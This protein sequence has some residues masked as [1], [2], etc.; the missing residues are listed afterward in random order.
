MDFYRR[1]SAEMQPKIELALKNTAGLEQRLRE[2][3]LVKLAHFAANREILRGAT[4]R[5]GADPKHRSRPSAPRS[6]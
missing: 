5:S 3:I 1:S 2:L 4:L 6:Q